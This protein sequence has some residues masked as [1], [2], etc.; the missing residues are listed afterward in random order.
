MMNYLAKSD[1]S[2]TV[3]SRGMMVHRIEIEERRGYVAAEFV[4]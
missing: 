2:V 4:R 3:I 1:E